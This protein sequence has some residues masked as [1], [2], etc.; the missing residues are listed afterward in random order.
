MI[1]FA[2][3]EKK[4]IAYLYKFFILYIQYDLNKILENNGYNSIWF[5]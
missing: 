5:F 4:L 3:E 1:E 2:L